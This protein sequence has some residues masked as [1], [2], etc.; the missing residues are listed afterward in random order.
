[1][2]HARPGRRSLAVPALLLANVLLACGPL[3]VR[4]ASS[5]SGVG[6]V[7]A[8]MWRLALA[9]PVMMAAT[10]ARR[11]VPPLPRSTVTLMVALA[12]LA[13]AADLGFWHVGILHTRLANATLFGNVTALLFPLYGFLV[14]RA[15][16]RARQ[17]LA[18]AFAGCGLVLLLGRSY[19]LS[20][21]YLLG[22]L[23]CLLA[24]LCYTL[25]LIV[26]DRVRGGIGPFA[27][28]AL[29]SIGG[30]PVLLLFA[31]GLGE[32]IWPH[33]WWPLVALSIGSQILGQ[34]LILYAIARVPPLGVGLMLLVQPIVSAAT[35]WLVYGEALGA[36]D[37]LGALCV[38]TAVLLVRETRE[39]A[40]P[41]AP[42]GLNPVP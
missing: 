18:L 39:K 27:T 21:R 2:T 22:D 25:Y 11:E 41:A 42:S 19:E 9:L 29:A 24:G 15:W 4:L 38:V 13:F 7:A 34:S 36:A 12:G 40:L 37:A 3:L 6:P 5:E 20:S 31:W 26:L 32:T 23:F 16:P 17:W 28:L 8:G 35:G 30:A 14:A 10:Y 1:M 33:V